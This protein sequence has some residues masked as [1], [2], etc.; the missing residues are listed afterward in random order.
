MRHAFVVARPAGVVIQRP[1]HDDAPL[2]GIS[3]GGMIVQLII[4]IGAF[5]AVK[6]MPPSLL[7]QP[8]LA[9]SRAMLSVLLAVAALL[10]LAAYAAWH[11]RITWR[12]PREQ[13]RVAEELA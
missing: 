10:T 12:A 2:P 9:P 11:D 5:P 6:L 4:N 3:I 7:Y 8:E 13:Q 1:G